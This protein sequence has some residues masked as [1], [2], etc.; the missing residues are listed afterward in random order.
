MGLRQS[1]LGVHAQKRVVGVAAQTREQARGQLHR[2]DVFLLQERRQ[3]RH[4][5]GVQIAHGLLDHF[6]HQEQ[7]AF[8][9]RCAALVGFAL[10][11]LAHRVVAQA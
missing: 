11:V 1:D 5:Q 9:R 2:A 10:V 3:L 4:A 7:A 6:R 8:H